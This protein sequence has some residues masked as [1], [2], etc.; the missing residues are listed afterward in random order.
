MG[1]LPLGFAGAVRLKKEPKELNSPSDAP[2]VFRRA[3]VEA[4]FPRVV[5]LPVGLPRF[6]VLRADDTLRLVF[7]YLRV[8]SFPPCLG[9]RGL[10]AAVIFEAL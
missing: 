2:V 3:R 4:D 5:L 10:L 1:G 8:G 7:V 6:A 9:C